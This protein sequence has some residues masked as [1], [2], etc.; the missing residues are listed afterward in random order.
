MLIYFVQLQ[1]W[2]FE[3]IIEATIGYLHTPTF[4]LMVFLSLRDTCHLLSIVLL[5]HSSFGHLTLNI[6]RCLMSIH[7]SNLDLFFPRPL[8]IAILQ[9]VLISCLRSCSSDKM[10]VIEV[11]YHYKWSC[12]QSQATYAINCVKL[13]ENGVL[14][15]NHQDGKMV[16]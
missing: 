13:D 2:I 16:F 3:F 5:T 8:N 14:Q 4:T 15:L 12:F 6:P 1:S 9:P 10:N 11:P 7:K